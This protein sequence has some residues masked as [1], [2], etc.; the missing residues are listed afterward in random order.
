MNRK[1]GFKLRLTLPGDHPL[2]PGKVQLM[3]LIKTHGSIR[4]A[5][6]AMNMSYRRAWLLIDELNG[7]FREPVVLKAQGG[8]QGGGATLTPFGEELLARFR[9]M[10]KRAE[11]AMGGDLEWIEAALGEPM[12]KKGETE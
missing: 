3:E 9:S 11:K 5:G 10:E 2:G 12:V 4:S 7:M 1:V 8:K 6:A